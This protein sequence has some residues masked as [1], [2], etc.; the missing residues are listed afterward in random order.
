[1]L[2]PVAAWDGVYHKGSVH[3]GQRVLVGCCLERCCRVC[4]PLVVLAVWP[5]VRR[6]SL[7]TGWRATA[8]VES[9]QCGP[10]ARHLPHE[11]ARGG[12]SVLGKDF[13]EVVRIRR[14][15]ISLTRLRGGGRM[16]VLGK[17]FTE[18]V[19]IR[20]PGISLTMVARGGMSVLGKDLTEVVRILLPHEWACCK[21][22][23][24]PAT[25]VHLRESGWLL[26]EMRNQVGLSTILGN[27]GERGNSRRHGIPT[28]TPPPHRQ[29]HGT[30]CNKTTPQ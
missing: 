12:L 13:T 21:G 24:G 28:K 16:S 17:D 20:R 5:R 6:A 8:W 2:V 11:V 26:S 29:T 1:M 18:V 7:R 15:G 9:S 22:L 23:V 10:S 27:K 19:R 25:Q 3:G 4:A 30:P 14:P